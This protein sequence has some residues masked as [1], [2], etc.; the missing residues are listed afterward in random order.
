MRKVA[1]SLT[2]RNGTSPSYLIKHNK[3][4]EFIKGLVSKQGLWGF[5]ATI[6]RAL[7][8]YSHDPDLSTASN[9]IINK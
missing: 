9:F 4:Q 8:L 6:V 1:L 2:F 7:R 5:A 3:K